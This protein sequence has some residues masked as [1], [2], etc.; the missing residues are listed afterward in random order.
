MYREN[1]NRVILSVAALSCAPPPLT[2]RSIGTLHINAT[3]H[4]LGAPVLRSPPSPTEEQQQQQ[5]TRSRNPFSLLF[6]HFSP[7]SAPPTRLSMETLDFDNRRKREALEDGAD[8]PESSPRAPLVAWK[9][10]Q[11]IRNAILQATE[12]GKYRLSVAS[13]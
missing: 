3:S 9:H 6:A 12:D 7:R 2:Y 4:T 11:R 13:L 1:N 10:D 8:L 5:A